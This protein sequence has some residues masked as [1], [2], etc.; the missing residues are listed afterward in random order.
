MFEIMF[1]YH[2]RKKFSQAF[3]AKLKGSFSISRHG[4]QFIFK[5]YNENMELFIDMLTSEIEN[6]DEIVNESTFN[7]NIYTSTI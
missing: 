4:G 6:I 1:S 2:V 3:N 5:G 7:N